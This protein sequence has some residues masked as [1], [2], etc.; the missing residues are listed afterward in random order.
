M[1]VAPCGSL[2]IVSRDQGA[3]K[4]ATITLPPSS[5]AFAAVASVSSTEKVTLQCG[6]V[7]RWSSGIGLRLATTSSKRVGHAHLRDLLADAGV[8][9]LEV[10]AVAHQRPHLGA[11]EGQRG[12]AEQRAVEGL[13]AVYIAGV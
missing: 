9:A 6:G 5:V 10:V 2:M 3:S 1:K 12:P 13:R 8:V 7:S 4:G 11:V